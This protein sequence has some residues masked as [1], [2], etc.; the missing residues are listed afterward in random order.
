MLKVVSATNLVDVL[1][2]SFSVSDF[3]EHK[4]VLDDVV[5]SMALFAKCPDAGDLEIFIVASFSL[6]TEKLLNVTG[7]PVFSH[8]DTRSE[9]DKA[10]SLAERLTTALDGMPYKVVP[11]DDGLHLMWRFFDGS[12]TLSVWNDDSNGTQSISLDFIR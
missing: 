1:R 9:I 4:T 10:L 6:E 7:I 5:K 11:Q 2:G 3:C 12:L 8:D